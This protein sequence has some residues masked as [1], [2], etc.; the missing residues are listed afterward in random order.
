MYGEK[1]FRA[2]LFRKICFP[3][4]YWFEDTINSF[5]VS[6]LAKSVVLLPECLYYYRQHPKSITHVAGHE[7]KVIDTNWITELVMQEHE[8]LKLPQDRAF[9]DTFMKQGMVNANRL[10]HVPTVIRKSVFVLT[11]DMMAQ[12]FDDVSFFSEKNP[13]LETALR[14]KD[15]GLYR[16]VCNAKVRSA[17]AR[18]FY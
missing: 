7:K 4:G 17:K 2:D 1:L 3:Q 14:K 11:C 18:G 15:Y 5:L 16:L 6:F 13:E 9:F 12:Y 10:K 8:L